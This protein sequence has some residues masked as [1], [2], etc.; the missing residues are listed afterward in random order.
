MPV[1]I[2]DLGDSIGRHRRVAAEAAGPVPEPVRVAADGQRPRLADLRHGNPQLLSHRRRRAAGEVGVGSDLGAL[3]QGD[4]HLHNRL[5][6]ADAAP[7]RERPGRSENGDRPDNHTA[8]RA[9]QRAP[10]ASQ[11]LRTPSP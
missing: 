7:Q 8:G 9:A 11:A 3:A 6:S 5:S 10:I 4:G 1:E 2:A